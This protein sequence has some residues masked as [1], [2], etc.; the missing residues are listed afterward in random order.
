MKDV[1]ADAVINVVDAKVALVVSVV[2]TA[3]AYG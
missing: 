1:D 2:E 3:A